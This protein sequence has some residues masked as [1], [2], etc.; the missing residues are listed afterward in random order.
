MA[1]SPRTDRKFRR[2]YDANLPPIRN[3]LLRRLP[4]SEVSDAIAEVFV[5]VWRRIDEAPDSDEARLWMYGIARNVA[6]NLDRSMRRRTRLTGR[7]WPVGRRY[8]PGP[9]TLVVRREQEAETLKAL[10]ELRNADQEIL[11]LRFW[12]ELKNTEIA[13]VL[14]IDP[15][16]VTMRL[17]RARNRLARR[18]GMTKEP[19]P[20][21]K[22]PQPVGEG[23]E[24]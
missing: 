16:A 21:I 23:G 20:A 18:L 3:Y 11:R 19:I 22:D 17:S 2:L 9:E 1:R 5:V 10:A 12:E 24:Q 8:E 14:D 4:A 7:L 15:H 13:E 6:R